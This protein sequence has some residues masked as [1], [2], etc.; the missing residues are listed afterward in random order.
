MLEGSEVNS[1]CWALSEIVA[2][3]KVTLGINKACKWLNCTEGEGAGNLSW[4][5]RRVEK[6]KWRVE[7]FITEVAG[8]NRETLREARTS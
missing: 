6:W 3:F 8:R 5:S 2:W 4:T 1:L 7:S